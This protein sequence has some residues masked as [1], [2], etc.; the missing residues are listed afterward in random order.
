MRRYAQDPHWLTARYPSTC[1]KCGGNTHYQ[2]YG[3]AAGGIGGYTVCEC[4]EM[5]E[6]K[7]DPEGE[8][9][10]PREDR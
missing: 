10:S 1:H 7:P 8:L 2:M 3:L 4:G 9:I 5:L 6:V